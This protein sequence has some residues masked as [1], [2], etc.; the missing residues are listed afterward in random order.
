MTIIA[1]VIGTVIECDMGVGKTGIGVLIA[2]GNRHPEGM[3]DKTVADN[4]VI[5]SYLTTGSGKSVSLRFEF[6]CR[7][8]GRRGSRISHNGVLALVGAIDVY[9]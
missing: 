7:L 2:G 3:A 1:T 5:F 4:N 9:S 6:R 8:G